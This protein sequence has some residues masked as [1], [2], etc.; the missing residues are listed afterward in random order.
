M[1]TSTTVLGELSAA[2]LTLVVVTG[3]SIVAVVAVLFV[4]QRAL[5]AVRE[6]KRVLDDVN[7]RAMPLI[8]ELAASLAE[9]N[10]ELAR[11]DRLV[12]SAESISATVDATSKLAYRALSAPVIKTVAMTSG[13]SRAARRL[14]RE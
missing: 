11:V 4:L 5:T 3:C 2:D 1:T 13:A 12:G 6:V 7:A 14:R 10:E 8:D 9:A